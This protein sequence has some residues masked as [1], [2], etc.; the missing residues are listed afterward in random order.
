MALLAMAFLVLAL[1]VV[2]LQALYFL[3]EGGLLP[4]SIVDGLRFLRLG[5]AEDPHTLA[6]LH[7]LLKQ[8]PLSPVLLSLAAI[9]FFLRGGRKENPCST[10]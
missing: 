1:P 7:A 5:W 9:C 8:A 3:K 10:T 6:W 4:V 2:G